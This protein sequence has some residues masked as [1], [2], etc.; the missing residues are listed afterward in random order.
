VT[1]PILREL[2]L[3]L[4]LAPVGLVLGLVRDAWLALTQPPAC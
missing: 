2:F 3:L 4:F 1:H